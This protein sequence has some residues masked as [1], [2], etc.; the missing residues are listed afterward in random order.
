MDRG[1]GMNLIEFT[2]VF[3]SLCLEKAVASHWTSAIVRIMQSLKFVIIY[4]GGK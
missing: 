1:L 3:T 2:L 4:C